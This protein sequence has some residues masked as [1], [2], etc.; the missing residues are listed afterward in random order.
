MAAREHAARRG[1]RVQVVAGVEVTTRDGHLLALY[2][3]ERPPALRGALETAE[4]VARRGGLCIAAHPFTRWTH[5][6][7]ARPVQQ[8]AD[9]GLLA[10]VEVFNASPAGRSSQARAQRFAQT[11][12]LA[13]IG[14]SDAHM[15][16]CV[17]LTH[18][19]FTGRT[20]EDLRRALE[21]RTTTADGRFAR[22]GEIAAEALPQLA[23]SMIHLPLR[24]L[25]RGVAQASPRAVRRL[26]RP[27]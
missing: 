14:A 22:T 19:R 17:A 27:S 18:T 24:R 8:L 7:A 21:G 3:E 12:G 6:L 11:E 5:S 26:R 15:L 13:L 10:G 16:R 20:P 4:W 25:A 9:R 1:Y 2:L 23:R